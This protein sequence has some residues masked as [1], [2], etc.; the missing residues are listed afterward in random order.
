M[1]GYD[2]DRDLVNLRSIA[3]GEKL[4][5]KPDEQ[6]EIET[7]SNQLDNSDVRVRIKVE[8]DRSSEQQER[9][10]DRGR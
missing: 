4:E 3:R 8:N 10:Y 5:I 6:W 7:A 1:I 2:I 9:G